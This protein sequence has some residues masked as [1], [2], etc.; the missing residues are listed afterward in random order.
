MKC[1]VRYC[2]VL[3]PFQK[4]VTG[5]P[6]V[7]ILT[8]G[9]LLAHLRALRARF[10]NE[11]ISGINYLITKLVDHMQVCIFMYINS[12]D[13]LIAEPRTKCTGVRQK[14]ACGQNVHLRRTCNVFFGRENV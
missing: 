11:Q 3:T 8:A 2:P 13:L 12:A 5:A 4:D 10:G 6:Q 1:R 7:R 14:C 9:A